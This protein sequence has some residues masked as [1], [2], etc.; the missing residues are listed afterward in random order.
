M[1]TAGIQSDRSSGKPL[2]FVAFRS[3][4]KGDEPAPKI[5]APRQK[6]ELDT[7]KWQPNGELSEQVPQTDG[8]ICRRAGS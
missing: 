8:F 3:S 1:D 5:D 7:G 4:E 2:P 6:R